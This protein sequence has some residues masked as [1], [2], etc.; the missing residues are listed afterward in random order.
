MVD[1]YKFNLR[2]SKFQAK[3]IVRERKRKASS[4]FFHVKL[5]FWS[6]I[7]AVS[8]VFLLFFIEHFATVFWESNLNTLPSWL[9]DLQKRIPKPMYPEDR[10]AIVELISVIASITGVI[11]ALFYPILA[12]IASTAYA[13][14]H[15][16]IRNLLL[17][18]EETQSYLR[19]LTYLTACSITVLLFLS[20]HHLPGNLV[21]SFLAL[22]CFT[23]LFGIL[24][25]GLGVYNFFEP[26]TL[27][28][29]VVNESIETIKNVTTDGEAWNDAN[30]Q[31]HYHKLATQQTENL[32][33]I[34]SLCLKDDDLKETSFISSIRSSFFI[35]NY[36]LASKPKIPIDSLW[37]PITFQFISY[38]EGD[39]NRRTMA[40]NTNTYIQPKQMQNH[41]W[42]EERII[43]NISVGIESIVKSGQIKAFGKTMELS[44]SIINSLSWSTDIK[45]L[46]VLLKKL[47]YNIK[48]ISN[49]KRKEAEII[50]YDEW[51]EELICV[52]IYCNVILRFQAGF[53]ERISQIDST[54]ILNEYSKINWNKNDSIYKSDFIPDLYD[55]LNRYSLFVNNEQDIEGKQVT[56]DWYFKQGVT[57]EYLFKI[58]AKIIETI[59]L[60]DTYLLSVAKHFDSEN[61]ALLCSY[62]IHIG[63]ELIHKIRHRMESVNSSLNDLDTLEVCKGE[64]NWSKLNLAEIESILKGYEQESL[65]LISSNIEKLSALKWEDQYPDVFAQS[66]SILST[67]IDNSFGEVNSEQVNKYFPKF[68]KAAVEGFNLLNR[69]YQGSSNIMNSH[70][71]LL[72]LMEISGYAYI[73]SVIYSD[74]SYWINVT[75]SWDNDFLANTDNIKLLVQIYSY[76]KNGISIGINYIEK[77]QRE[78]TFNAVKE[79][80]GLTPRSTDDILVQPFL[81]D[82]L[83]SGDFIELFIEIYLFTF[84]EAKDA[85]SSLKKRDMFERI[86]W[87]INNPKS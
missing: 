11:L 59:K 67:H 33:L 48:T 62:S 72:D 74:S 77:T 49:K 27:S 41:F 36:Y 10:D 44:Y 28:S 13:K 32:S 24:K 70:Q 2:K 31:K 86:I 30:F 51:R 84:V 1:K 17:Y 45:T 81:Q 71:T 50:N 25:I 3:R 43:G 66:Y 69:R 83:H 55:T 82:S 61:N 40:K 8:V 37:F 63:L 75:K 42:F 14:V 26:S 39:M 21:L 12:T 5:T 68:L 58:T 4:N 23:T 73:Y 16:S 76:S 85:V 34:T 65:L 6:I 87:H 29:I 56:P 7:K 57:A 22:Y 38:F 53:F 47:N 46:Q 18:E 60:F 54:K 35:L 19:R 79:K 15:A 80:M 52:E 64:F 20:F 78:N 9:V